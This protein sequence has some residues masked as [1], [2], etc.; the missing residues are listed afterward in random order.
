MPEEKSMEPESIE[1]SQKE[2]ITVN[3]LPGSEYRKIIRKYLRCV[4]WTYGIYSAFQ[5]LGVSVGVIVKTNWGLVNGGF[6]IL[7]LVALFFCFQIGHELKKAIFD[8][9]VVKKRL[10]FVFLLDWVVAIY[11]VFSLIGSI[12][13]VLAL[14]G[15]TPSPL[16]SYVL[17]YAAIMSVLQVVP[18]YCL[19]AMHNE[20][21]EALGDDESEEEAEDQE[22]IYEEIK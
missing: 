8:C 12:L 6:L 1:S 10:K 18:F 15:P 20:T 16:V 3:S 14:V 4:K 19:I 21:L 17:I 22:E 9:K 11:D 2:S 13:Y 7:F 5:I